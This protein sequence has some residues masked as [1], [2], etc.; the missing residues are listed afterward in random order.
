MSEEKEDKEENSLSQKPQ[1]DVSSGSSP[2]PDDLVE[3]VPELEKLSSESRRKI[4]SVL[5][6]YQKHHSGPL[7][8]PEDIELYN[9]HI[10]DGGDRIMQMA[11]S[12]AAHRMNM[13]SRILSTQEGH[14]KRGQVFA[15][16]IG[17]FG[18]LTGAI[19]TILGHDVVGGGIAGTTVVSLVY[20][21]VSG[22]KGNNPH[23]KEN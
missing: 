23:A 8:A 13:E 20:A 18:I 5:G 12:Q 1:E 15:L 3:L 11:E 22:K 2:T 17:I 7:P 16:S 10:P 9:K 14:N 6:S 4:I 19:V 21:F